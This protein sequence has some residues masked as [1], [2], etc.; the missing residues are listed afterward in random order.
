MCLW[1][2]QQ[3]RFEFGMPRVRNLAQRPDISTEVFR[4]F[5][6]S[7]PANFGLGSG[8]RLPSVSFSFSVSLIILSFC[9]T[10]YNTI[11]SMRR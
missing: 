8:F 5:L 4:V 3:S 7:F 9:A 1:H 11:Y 6:P 2:E 10:S